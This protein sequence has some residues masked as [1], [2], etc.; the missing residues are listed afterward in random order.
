MKE[1]G[2]L[3]PDSNQQS[4]PFEGFRRRTATWDFT[5][6]TVV[7]TLSPDPEAGGGARERGGLSAGTRESGLGPS[8]QEMERR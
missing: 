1:S 7:T 6:L 3:T 5:Q 8:G 2:G 4:A